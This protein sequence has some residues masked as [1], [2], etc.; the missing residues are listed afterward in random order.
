MRIVKIS[1]MNTFFV[2][3]MIMAILLCCS[4]QVQ[5]AQDG[6]YTYTVTDGKAQITKYTGSGEAVTIPSTLG[7]YSVSSIGDLAFYFCS[8]L[9]SISFPESVISIGGWAFGGEYG[10]PDLTSV[11]FNSATT[12][13]YDSEYTIPTATK[14]I[15]YDPSTANDYAAKY[16]R[17][18]EV[19]GAIDVEDVK[20]VEVKVSVPTIY[21]ANGI[22]LNKVLRESGIK[23][24]DGNPVKFRLGSENEI[25]IKGGDGNIIGNLKL[26]VL[27][28]DLYPTFETDSDDDLRIVLRDSAEGENGKIRLTVNRLSGALN[29]DGVPAYA[30]SVTSINITVTDLIN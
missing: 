25:L 21:S 19:I 30:T 9:T 23:T 8:G 6:D 26:S 1:K 29:A 16:N 12:T 15:G 18:F 10:C 27:D 22:K 11:I 7:G 28:G 4:N 17:T 14:I 13:L 20:D 2:G 5:A 3:M 24:D